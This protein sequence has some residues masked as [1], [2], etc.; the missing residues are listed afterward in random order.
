MLIPTTRMALQKTGGSAEFAVDLVRTKWRFQF[1]HIKSDVVLE[2][3]DEDAAG[4]CRA[5]SE[6]VRATEKTL[7]V[8]MPK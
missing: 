7:A 8:K 4:H 2:K 5:N 6:R 3:N 1:R